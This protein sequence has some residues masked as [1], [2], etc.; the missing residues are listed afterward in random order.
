MVPEARIKTCM[1]E[2]ELFRAWVA[3]HYAEDIPES[4]SDERIRTYNLV[5]KRVTDHR[6][7]DRSSRIAEI[8]DGDIDLLYRS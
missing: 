2:S 7:N 1:G 3:R 8:L 4:R 6:T 5:D